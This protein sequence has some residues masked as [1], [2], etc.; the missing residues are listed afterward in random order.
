MKT[1]IS[2]PDEVFHWADQHAKVK[3]VSRSKLIAIAL[4]QYRASFST[5]EMTRQAN[6]YAQATREDIKHSKLEE[7]IASHAAKM[8]REL[9]PW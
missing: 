8:W 3:G 9:G 6:A 7:N 5:E 4:E 2:I 1:A